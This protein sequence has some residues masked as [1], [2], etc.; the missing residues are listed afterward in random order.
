MASLE[1]VS[2]QEQDTPAERSARFAEAALMLGPRRSLVT[3]IARP[4]APCRVDGPTV[5]ILNTGITH[6]VG[7]HRMYVHLSRLLAHHGHTVVRFDQSG[8]GDSRPRSD[9]LAPLEA[10]A[11]DIGEMLDSLQN[12]HQTSRFVL[13]GLCAGADHAVLYAR[14]DPRVVGV[15]IM[16]PSLPPTR[17]Y[18]LHRALRQLRHLRSWLSLLTGRSGMMRTALTQ[19]RHRLQPQ[20]GQAPVSL[21][22]LRFSPALAQCYSAIALRRVRMLAVFTSVSTYARQLLDA[23]PEVGASGMFRQELFSDSDHLFSS[24]SQRQRLFELTLD[25]LAGG[26]QRV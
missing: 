5:V 11:A 4:H 2:I 1:N 8:I 16:D 25:W 20:E 24:E 21:I 10:A 12:L 22:N 7:H 6:R 9:G 26:I 19:L 13:V 15:M 14:N 23:F 17:G 3:V 18:Y